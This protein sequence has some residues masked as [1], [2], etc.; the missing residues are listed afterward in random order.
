VPVGGRMVCCRR[1]WGAPVAD[2]VASTT[3]V[4]GNGLVPIAGEGIVG[5][6]FAQRGVEGL[7]ERPWLAGFVR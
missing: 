1:L 5:V 6:R 2:V 4:A 3:L 7:Q